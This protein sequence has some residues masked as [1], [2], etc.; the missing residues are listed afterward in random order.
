MPD[1]GTMPGADSPTSHDPSPNVTRVIVDK[2]FPADFRWVRRAVQ[3]A[4]TGLDA[5]GVPGPA[6]GSAEIVLAEALNNVAE[7]AYPEGFEGDIRLIIRRRG[8]SLM[9]EIRDKGPSDAARSCRQ[10]AFPSDDR[11]RRATRRRRKADSV[12]S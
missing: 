7:H 9:V 4:V 12:G 3:T 11:R 6:L 5:D 2:T 8:N 1:D 10:M